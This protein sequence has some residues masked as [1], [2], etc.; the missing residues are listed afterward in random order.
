GKQALQYTITEGYL[1]LK[2]FIA[3]RYQEKKGLEVSPDQVLILNG[4]QQGIDLTGKAFLDDGDP[5]MI[6]NPSF[7]GALQ[8]Y[9]I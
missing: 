6:E 3:Q 7:I 9:S 8:S 1:P 2:E 5:V 4:S